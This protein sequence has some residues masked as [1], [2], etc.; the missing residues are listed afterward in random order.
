MGLGN[1]NWNYGNKGSN[2]RY[3]YTVVELLQKIAGNSP[4]GLATE[5]TL[6]QVLAALGGGSRVPYNYEVIILDG[7]IQT[8]D[9]SI[10]ATSPTAVHVYVDS[11]L[12]GKALRYTVDG[13]MTPASG[14]GGGIARSD[15]DEFELLD[16]ASLQNF[17]VT[18][19]SS[20]NTALFV[21]YYQ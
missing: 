19:E 14:P 12:P 13:V 16:L 6:L 11:D 10:I 1:G 3:E 7:S 8:F 2:W 5:A 17:Q 18:W 15:N 21:T 4:N 9:P 20:G